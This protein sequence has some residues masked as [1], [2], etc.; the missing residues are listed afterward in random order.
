MPFYMGGGIKRSLYLDLGVIVNCTITK[1]I[2]L[3]DYP[4][5]SHYQYIIMTWV[6]VTNFHF[7]NP[8]IRLLS[9]HYSFKHTNTSAREV[10]ASEAVLGAL[11]PSSIKNLSQ[12]YNSTQISTS[13]V[14]YTKDE[15]DLELS[16][17]Y[18]LKFF[19]RELGTW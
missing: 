17:K 11:S 1:P 10:R 14:L 19:F 16:S 9:R 2:Q 4:S 15:S 12:I 6:F 5:I 8:F 3:F 7:N 18:L 13:I